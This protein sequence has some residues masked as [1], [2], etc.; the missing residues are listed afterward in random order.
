MPVFDAYCIQL[1]RV[2][3]ITEARTEYLNAPLYKRFDFLCSTVSCRTKG[4][5]IVGANY[6][7]HPSADHYNKAYFRKYPSSINEHCEDCYL[8][9]DDNLRM[10]GESEEAFKL[11]KV[12]ANLN[13]YV[14]EFKL[15]QKQ[16]DRGTSSLNTNS[17]NHTKSSPHTTVFKPTE[18]NFVR[19]SKTNQLMRLVESYL[20]S[21]NK[22]PNE[23]FKKLPLK[24]E[25]QE[26]K[27]LYQYF[28]NVKKGIEQE[29]HCVYMGNAILRQS[30]KGLFF[31]FIETIW[32][33]K[34][35]KN[36]VR[37]PI[38]LTITKDV[39]N[40][41]RYRKALLDHINSNPYPEK[42][43]RLFFIPN[44]SDIKS[45]L[46]EKDGKVHEIHSFNMTDLRLFCLFTYNYL[47]KKH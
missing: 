25:G 7:V 9:Y 26:I 8:Y 34:K 16:E 5:K 41:Y 28:Y 18:H 17:V 47:K 35:P 45:K 23:V 11:R 37:L 31:Q 36:I 10:N 42:R 22:L 29:K 2:V 39:L 3:T 38:Y 20:D 44:E 6:K 15:F 24:V 43:F 1:K 40:N 19:Y 4:V 33:N 46:I 14:D 12:R 30:D 27:Y 13:D 21:R 32:E